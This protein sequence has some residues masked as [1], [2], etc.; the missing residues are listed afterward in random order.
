M[1]ITKIKAGDVFNENSKYIFKGIKQDGSFVLTHLPSGEEVNIAVNYVKAYLN[2]GDQFTSTKK[3]SKEDRK[4][5]EAGIRSIFEEIGNDV[6]TV[7][8]RKQNKVLSDKKLKELKEKQVSEQLTKIEKAQKSKTGVLKE[9]KAALESIIN[10]P[11]NNIELG[12]LRVLR[13]YKTQFRSNDGL[14]N[15]FDMDLPDGLKGSNMRSVN[16]N[17]I[18]YLIVGGV[19]YIVE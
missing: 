1:D 16:I 7:C 15:C 8:F 6:F 2:S 12:E 14:Y 11:I 5:G 19:K 13:G 4:T 17:T 10:N 3:V 18:Q 9:A